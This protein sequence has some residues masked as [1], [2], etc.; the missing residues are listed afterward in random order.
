MDTLELLFVVILLVLLVVAAGALIVLRRRAANGKRRRAQRGRKGEASLLVEERPAVAPPPEAAEAAEVA[1]IEAPPEPLALV[2]PVE[3]A[4]P[5]RPLNPAD[6]IAAASNRETLD[7]LLPAEPDCARGAFL[8]WEVFLARMRARTLTCR[9]RM[10]SLEERGAKDQELRVAH[11]QLDFANHRSA[12]L[13]AAYKEELACSEAVLAF[14][15]TLAGKEDDAAGRARDAFTRSAD[16]IGAERFFVQWSRE[17]GR[18]PAQAARALFLAG[19]LAELRIA[20]PE[21]LERYAQAVNLATDNAEYLRQAGALAHFMERYGDASRWRT[22]LVRLGRTLSDHSLVDSALVQRDLAYTCL[23][24]GHVEEAGRIY[25]RAMQ[26]LVA[27]LGPNHPEMATAWFQI[28]ELQES[29]G[30]P[31][32]A[33]TLYERCLKILQSKLGLL[34]PALCPVLENLARLA[35]RLGRDPEALAYSR[36]LVTI[37]EKFLPP[38]HPHLA[39]ALNALAEVYIQRGEYALAEH[40]G[41]KSLKIHEALHGREHPLVATQ[42]AQLSWVCAQQGKMDDARLYQNEADA[43]YTALALAPEAET[44]ASPPSADASVRPRL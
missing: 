30:A 44:V 31:E 9:L 29:Q 33:W 37:Q 13:E 24:A 4:E 40:C 34:D 28:G 3:P 2:E 22:A 17:Q 16:P 26:V 42:L 41:V 19:R 43:L 10:E 39:E 7:R 1:V 25:K 32:Q 12:R 23:K 15:E 21:A 38:N 6:G 35:T 8:P 11:H 5:E 36:R 27:A 14:L 20:L 18:D